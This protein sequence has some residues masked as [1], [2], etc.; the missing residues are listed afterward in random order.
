MKLQFNRFL[1]SQVVNA[2]KN[3]SAS[4]IAKE[5][6][7]VLQGSDTSEPANVASPLVGDEVV[8]SAVRTYAVFYDNR[9][10]DLPDRTT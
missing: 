3:T 10:N 2:Y 9:I 4:S 5:R 1:H 6:V 8:G 7:T